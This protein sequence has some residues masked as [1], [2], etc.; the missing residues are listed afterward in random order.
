MWL[1]SGL[2]L[3]LSDQATEYNVVGHTTVEFVE[4]LLK[5]AVATFVHCV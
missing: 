1:H 3:L 2:A 5:G 4:E